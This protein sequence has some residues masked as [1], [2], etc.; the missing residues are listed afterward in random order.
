MLMNDNQYPPTI[1]PR[2]WGQRASWPPKDNSRNP[3]W[4]YIGRLGLGSIRSMCSAL[5]AIGE[6]A[7]NGTENPV[8]FPWPR[9]RCQH[10]TAIRSALAK[11]Y[12]P[13]TANKMLAALR[14]ILKEC[15]KLGWM[16]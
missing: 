6:I 15:Q 4:A 9:L 8:F 3:L 11:R 2:M 16:S 13:A 12:K 1:A 7:S 10:T 14:G 5:M